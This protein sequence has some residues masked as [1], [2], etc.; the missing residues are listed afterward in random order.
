MNELL[1]CPWEPASFLFISSNVPPLVHYSHYVAIFAALSIA[2]LVFL[3]DP[4][5]HVARLFLLF[6]GLFSVWT[7]FDVGLWSTN[8]P[9]VVMFLWSMQVLIEPLTFATALFLFYKY[10][11]KKSPPLWSVIA[12]IVLL[13]PLVIFLP[14]PLNLEALYLSSCETAEGPLAQY[15]TYFVNILFTMAIILLGI[16]EI[17]KIKD[18][19]QRKVARYFVFGLVIFLLTFTSGNIISSFT[20]DWTISQYGLFGMPIFAALIAYSIVQFKAFKVEIAA[21]QILVIAILA[22]ISSL[23]F[24]ND[25]YLSKLVAGATFF[26]ALTVGFLLI[27]SVRN[28]F[29]QRLQLEKLTTD[30]EKANVR[31]QTLDKQKS[32]FVSIASHQLRSPLT[33]IRGYASM[34]LEESYGKIPVSA[35]EPL[36][37]I[38]TSA[39]RM[40]LAV[41]EYLNVS[42][43]ESGNM[44]YELADFN[45]KD[46]IER[47]CDDVRPTALKSGL[48]LLFRTNL[49]SKGVVH[50]DVGKTVQIAHNLINNS[51]KYTEKGSISV[52]VRDDVNKKYTYVDVIDT[53]V[54]MSQETIDI[55]F[56]KFSRA[57][58][59]NRVNTTGT[60]LGLFVAFK[61]AEAMGGTITAHSAGEGKGSRFTLTL[62]L[63]M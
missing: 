58:G 23:L 29:L 34:L 57:E 38:E 19:Q 5:S 21:A 50:A 25:Q 55:L 16:K 46:E 26:F 52:Y 4:R 40:A 13:L 35:K 48:V 39:K 54:G 47:I 22:L 60:G 3:N 10:L 62:P 9:A 30:L 24:V 32:E 59:A 18:L 1:H 6:S 17:P 14:T 15:Y 11:K 63:A 56:Q 27:R 31:L 41:E 12:G 42:R 45:L 51:I 7:L 8:D 61:M 43:I 28:E 49:E 37:R 2:L 33:S 36:E 44:K 20:D 53:G